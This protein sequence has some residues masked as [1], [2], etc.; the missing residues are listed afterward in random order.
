MSTRHDRVYEAFLQR[1]WEEGRALAAESDLLDLLPLANTDGPPNYFIVRFYCK[2]L[3]RGANGEVREASEFHLGI[4]FPADYLRR[5]EPMQVITWL[6][7]LEVFHPNIRPPAICLGRIV[8]GT[9]LVD[10]L[11]RCFEIITYREWAAHD[12]LNIEAAQMARNISDRF[13]IDR[14]PLKRR[15]IGIEVRETQRP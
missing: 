12:A 8:P 1:Q 2:G 6:D 9:A 14:R 13:P 5:C 10:L 15:V 7:P 3:I 4:G 11:Y